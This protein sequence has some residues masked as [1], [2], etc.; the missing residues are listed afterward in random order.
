MPGRTPE[1]LSAKWYR[2]HEPKM[3]SKTWTDEET[4]ILIEGF[5]ELG[6]KWVQIARLLPGRTDKAVRNRF[7]RQMK[8]E[9][10][11]AAADP[12]VNIHRGNIIYR[13]S[14]NES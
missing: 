1:Q 3:D 12:N 6:G 9:E 4:K 13:Y 11:A 10:R 5:H 8:K 7:M 14:L 2:S